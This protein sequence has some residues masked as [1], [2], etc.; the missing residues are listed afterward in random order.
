MLKEV[1]YTVNQFSD[2]EISKS[3]S[4]IKY[5]LDC[6]IKHETDGIKK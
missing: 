6:G 2:M 1:E 4:R 3:I 5:V